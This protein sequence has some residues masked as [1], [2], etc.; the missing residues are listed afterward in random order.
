MLYNQ[1]IIKI[2]FLQGWYAKNLFSDNREQLIFGVFLAK[3]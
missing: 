1:L 3:F 2:L